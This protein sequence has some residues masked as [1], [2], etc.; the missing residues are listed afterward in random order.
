MYRAKSCA[1]VPTSRQVP[2]LSLQILLAF[3]VVNI[4]LPQNVS[5]KRVEENANMSFLRQTIRRALVVL[6]SVIYWLRELWSVALELIVVGCV[7]KKNYSLNRIVRTSRS[8]TCNRN[9]FDSFPMYRT[10]YEVRSAIT[11]TAELLVMGLL[12][13][14]Y[15]QYSRNPQL[16][17][18]HVGDEPRLSLRITFVIAVCGVCLRNT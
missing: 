14:V 9:Q 15:F 13:I 11:A 12:V 6:C 5:K 10:S 18:Q 8:T 7:H 17:A 1:S 2:Y 16:S 4:V 3:A